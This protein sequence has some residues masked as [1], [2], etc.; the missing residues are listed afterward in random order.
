MPSWA[1]L[2]VA[3][4][5]VRAHR[6]EIVS[7]EHSKLR[8]SEYSRESQ[9]SLSPGAAGRSDSRSAWSSVPSTSVVIAAFRVCADLWVRSIGVFFEVVKRTVKENYDYILI[10]SRTGV[11]DTSGICT[12]QMP[13]Q[14]VACFTASEQNIR[15]STAIA[16]SVKAQMGCACS[17]QFLILGGASFDSGA[18]LQSSMDLESTPF[19]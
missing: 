3:A 17:Y 1:V 16:A 7:V 5:T 10:D 6:K 11:S 9:L 15:G 14:L 19:E 13:D 12:V 18:L 2:D 8:P 4:T